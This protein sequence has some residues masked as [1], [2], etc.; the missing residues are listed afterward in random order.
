MVALSSLMA[1]L[2]HSLCCRLGI[3]TGLDLAQACRRLL[4]R[5]WVIPLWLP[6]EVAIVAC[7]LTLPVGVLVTAFDTLVLL[8]LQ[9]FGIRGLEALVFSMVAL[10]GACFAVEMLLVRPDMAS[11]LGGPLWC[12][13][14]AG[15]RVR[16]WVSGPSASPFSIR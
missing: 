11:V 2:L 3:A 4:P 1:V 6:A 15:A 16:R 7:G 14:G 10:V 5:G 12:R 13:P 9:R 8:E